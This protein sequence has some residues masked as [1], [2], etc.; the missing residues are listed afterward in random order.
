[1]AYVQ[2]DAP[3]VPVEIIEEP[4]VVQRGLVAVERTAEANG[5]R[6][7]TVLNP[8]H[9]GAEI[10]EHPS[11][12]WTGDYPRQVADPDTSQ[13]KVVICHGRDYRDHASAVR[14]QA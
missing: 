9:V 4:R 2:E 12:R 14:L 13:G 7:L 10:R 3:L 8:Y 11:C 5:V 1:M 6:C